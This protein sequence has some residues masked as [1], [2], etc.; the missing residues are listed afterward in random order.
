MLNLQ[1]GHISPQFHV[2][3]DDYFETVDSM[4]KVTEPAK[5]KWISSHKREYHLNDKKEI[6]DG[7]KTWIRAGK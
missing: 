6:T 7:A 2:V 3:F 4:R 5:W 1:T